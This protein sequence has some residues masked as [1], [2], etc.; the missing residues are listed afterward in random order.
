M[1]MDK[2]RQL[3]YH[4]L[5]ATILDM[6]QVRMVQLGIHAI[7]VNPNTPSLHHHHHII[8]HTAEATRLLI[9]ITNAL[10]VKAT[11]QLTDHKLT[12]TKNKTRRRK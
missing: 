11:Q 7:T 6:F 3:T 8:H 10:H 2:P 5:L 1:A 9:P 12:A 4:A